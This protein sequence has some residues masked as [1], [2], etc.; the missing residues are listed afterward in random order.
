MLGGAV[1]RSSFSEVYSKDVLLLHCLRSLVVC[2][3]APTGLGQVAD[4]ASR[5]AAR[6]VRL[7]CGSTTTQEPLVLRVASFLPFFHSFYLA[8]GIRLS[9][10]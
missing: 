2:A 7:L 10:R 4:V 3:Q 5:A 8:R 1:V 6:C 9:R